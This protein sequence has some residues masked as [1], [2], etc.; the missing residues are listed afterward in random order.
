VLQLVNALD[1]GIHEIHSLML[2]RHGA[3]IAEGWWSPYRAEDMHSL[4]SGT[5]S[6]NGTAVGML[7]SEGKLGLDDLVLSK[8]PDLAPAQ[9]SPNMQLMRIRD[10]LTM[11]TGHD[12]DTIDTL[13]KAPNGAWTKAFLATDVPNPPG[14]KFV[15]NSGAAYVLGA[16]VQRTTGMSVE[17]YL[18]PRLFEPL[19]IQQHLWGKSPEG[20]NMTDG[21]LSLRTEDFAKFGLLYLQGGV[22]NGQQV[23]PADWVSA[24]TSKQISTGN[25]DGNWNYG[26]GY[27]FWRNPPGGFRAD[28][29]LGQYAFVLPDRDVVLAITSGTNDTDQLMTTVWSNLV[30]A[31]QDGPL[32]DDPGAQQALGAK[33]ASLS[34]PL[35]SGQA[36]STMAANVSGIRFTAQSNSQGITALQVDFDGENPV[37]H[38]SDA[39]GEHVIPVG[40]GQWVRG[41]TDYEKHINDLF[42][43]TDEGIAAMGAWS[44]NDTFTAR[45]VF[46]ETPYTVITSFK[47]GSDRVALDVSYNVRWESTTEPEVLA[48]R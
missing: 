37:L 41:R 17:D 38:I 21:G 8:F 36:S 10:L 6:F 25:D 24:A 19:Q 45:L 48:T 43:T 3:V 32:P 35:P 23:V 26:Y 28:G 1:S 7:V 31:L 29:S 5:K 33:L 14:T 2:V 47:F 12:A 11:S 18:T 34:L 22:W 9:P 30:P 42:D 16:I 46:T 44:A 13:R 4:Y 15:Y 20:V 40:I 27:Q 39:D